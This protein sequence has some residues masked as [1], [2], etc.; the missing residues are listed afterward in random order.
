MKQ[1]RPGERRFESPE[2]LRRACEEYFDLCD[3]KGQIYSELGLILHL[4][5]STMCW[6]NWW[7]GR[8]S[9]D[10]MEECR[11][12]CLRIQ[13]Q[14]WTHPVYQEKGGMTSRAIFLLKQKRLGGMT[15]HIEARQDMTV[16]VKMG[17]GA[18]ESDFK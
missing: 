1:K 9:P 8:K 5:I 3:A 7:E 18:D 12:A 15:D 6:D 4:G 2:A 10:L 11:R 13:D 14:I 17:A 16:N